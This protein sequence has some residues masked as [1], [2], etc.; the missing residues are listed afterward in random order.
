MLS[1]ALNRA[2]SYDASNMAEVFLAQPLQIVVG[3]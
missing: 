1:N 2:E 3:S